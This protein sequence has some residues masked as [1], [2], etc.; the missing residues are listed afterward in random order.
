MSDNFGKFNDDTTELLANHK[1][2]WRCQKNRYW[3]DQVLAI[4]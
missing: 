2:A 1:N 3:I 4:N